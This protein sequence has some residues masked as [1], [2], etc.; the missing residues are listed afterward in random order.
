MPWLKL[1]D[2]QNPSAPPF[3]LDDL[4]EEEWHHYHGI[5]GGMAYLLNAALVTADD[6]LK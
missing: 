2:L 6:G 5:M 3:I 4:A 1:A